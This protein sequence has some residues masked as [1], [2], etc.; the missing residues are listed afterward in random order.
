MAQDSPSEEIT[1]LPRYGCRRTRI[2]ARAKEDGGHFARRR[3]H[4]ENF[5]FALHKLHLHFWRF[6][7]LPKTGSK[8][9][10][11]AE[12]PA[13]RAVTAFDGARNT[14]EFGLHEFAGSV[15]QRVTVASHIDKRKVRPKVGIG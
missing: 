2:I 1:G 7:I 10:A 8:S 9:N 12:S 6:A 5:G 3:A 14:N 11:I 15:N 4:N 13:I